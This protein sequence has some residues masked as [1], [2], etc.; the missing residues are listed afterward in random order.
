MRNC[1]IACLDLSD[2]TLKSKLLD[3][4]KKSSEAPSNLA[5][6]END[7]PIKVHTII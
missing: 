3:D 2:D 6:G 7:M 1:A 4:K 5:L